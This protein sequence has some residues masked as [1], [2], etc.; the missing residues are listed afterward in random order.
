MAMPVILQQLRNNQA[1]PMAARAKQLMDMVRAS[2]NPQ[3]MLNQ[4]VTQNPQFRQVMDIIQ[5]H[6]GDPMAAFRAVAEQKGVN[7]DEIL[8]MLR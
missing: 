6:G 4:L 7:P 1:N 2:G 5:Q 3:A 8:N